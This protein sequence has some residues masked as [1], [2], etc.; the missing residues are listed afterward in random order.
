M[1]SGSGVKRG[2]SALSLT[3]KLRIIKK[4][5]D[6]PTAKKIDLAKELGI[7]KSTLFTIIAKRDEILDN[8]S[9]S[10]SSCSKKKRV[11]QGRY[12]DME[13]CLL[14]WFKQNRAA[15][16][17]I[18][19]PILIAKAKE[20]AAKMHVP[21]TFTASEGWVHRFKLRFGIT[22]KKVCGE[23][24]AV[25]PETVS[26]WKDDLLPALL[27]DYALKDIFNA[28]ETGLFYNL[29]PDRTLALQHE[30]C[31]GGKR[32]K[33]RL[34]VLLC[35]NADGTEKLPPLVIGKF[36][37][38]RCFKNV[39][40]LPTPYTSNKKAWV[41]TK[42][43]GD[44]LRSIDAKMGA[45]HRK[46]ILLVDQCSAHPPDTSYLRNMKVKFFPANCTS[47]LQP[48]DLG[49][50]QSFKTKYRH[51]LLQRTINKLN[52]RQTDDMKL[53]VLQVSVFNISTIN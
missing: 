22:C 50:I 47:V 16:M 30:K 52:R 34:T 28:D 26:T 53:N 3:D 13:E 44:W 38:P 6:N 37:K 41:T 33:E 43:F 2:R 4:V 19:G 14:E 12:E 10:G 8:A 31:H 39:K 24:G 48:L 40:T 15:G 32:S 11:Q 36:A 5:D 51:Q 17:P 20:L 27:E 35:A 25:N 29:L 49:I 1:A 7:P 46:I 23:S 18:S 21:D 45:K 9:T 42:V